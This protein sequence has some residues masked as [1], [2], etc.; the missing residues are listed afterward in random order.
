MEYKDYLDMAADSVLTVPEAARQL[1]VTP[2]V[3]R[4]LI[5]ENKVNA[6]K[7]GREWF[8]TPAEI[9]RVKIEDQL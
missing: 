8:L 7:L 4:R 1:S 6:V 9:E 3:L 5:R 2:D